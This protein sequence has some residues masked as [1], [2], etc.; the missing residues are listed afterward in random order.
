MKLLFDQN[1]SPKLVN[2]LADIFPGSNHVFYLGMDESEDT[3]IWQYAKQNGFVLVTRDADFGDLSVLRGFP[4]N[5][6][7]IRRGNCSTKDI[8]GML[9]ENYDAIASLGQ[10]EF[11]GMIPLF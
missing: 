5:V 1:L 3:E 11:T 2:G 6:I 7:W 4:P 10:D 9:R 8:E